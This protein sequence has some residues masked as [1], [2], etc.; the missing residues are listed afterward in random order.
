MRPEV[1]QTQFSPPIVPIEGK[2][3]RKTSEALNRA[4]VQFCSYLAVPPL[5]AQHA[6]DGDEFSL[7]V[8]IYG[9]Y[10]RISKV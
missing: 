6:R 8:E 2:H 1:F 5:G 10:S 4:G 3:P 9:C 7:A